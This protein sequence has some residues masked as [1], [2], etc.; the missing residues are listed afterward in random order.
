MN[1]AGGITSGRP[2]VYWLSALKSPPLTER[3]PPRRSAKAGSIVVLRCSEVFEKSSRLRAAHRTV[4]A[5]RTF[6]IKPRDAGNAPASLHSISPSRPATGS[7]HRPLEPHCTGGE[8][9]DR[10]RRLRPALNRGG[11]DRKIQPN[12]R[13]PGRNWNGHHLW[14]LC[15][16]RVA[17]S[18]CGWTLLVRPRGVRPRHGHSNGMDAPARDK[19]RRPQPMRICL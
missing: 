14:L 17:F 15:R 2:L 12:C 13:A 8:F 7:R 4:V 9:R 11:P 16:S 10:Q 18:L 5:P 6:V 19:W 1:I 3:Q